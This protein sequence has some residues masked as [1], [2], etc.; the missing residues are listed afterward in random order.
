ML[1]YFQGYY[2]LVFS[3]VEC[4][5]RGFGIDWDAGHLCIFIL[6]RPTHH[7]L[8]PPTNTAPAFSLWPRARFRQR[9]QPIRSL[10][11][12]I[13]W[14]FNSQQVRYIQNFCYVTKNLCVY[15]TIPFYSLSYTILSGV[16]ISCVCYQTMFGICFI[17][18]STLFN[19]VTDQMW[20]PCYSSISSA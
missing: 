14:V 3:R 13:F 7:V 1:F 6:Y 8:H 9:A 10:P 4:A 18:F 20:D 19:S 11:L 17:L 2:W 12:F 15:R 5:G 16:T